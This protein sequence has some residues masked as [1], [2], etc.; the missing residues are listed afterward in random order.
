MSKDSPNSNKY[1]RY[2][3]AGTQMLVTIAGGVLLGNWLDKT[4]HTTTPW[5]SIGCSLLF[6]F[7]EIYL[8]IRSLPKE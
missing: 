7:A 6:I 3:G 1:M 5:Y 2:M 8:L 4:L